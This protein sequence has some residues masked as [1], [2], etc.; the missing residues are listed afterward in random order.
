N[1]KI[2]LYIFIFFYF[3]FSFFFFFFFV[4]GAAPPPPTTR[5][6]SAWEM[7]YTGYLT[8]SNGI[9]LSVRPCH[10]FSDRLSAKPRLRYSDKR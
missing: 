4:V 2:I 3:F 5:T 7:L 6:P 1:I 9:E 10:A 8:L